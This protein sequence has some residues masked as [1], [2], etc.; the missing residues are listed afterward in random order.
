MIEDRTILPK[1]V[2]NLVHFKNRADKDTVEP[3]LRGHSDKRPTPLERPLVSENS[4]MKVLI[5]TPHS[6]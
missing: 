2:M 5:S 3:L 1:K 4:N 6:W